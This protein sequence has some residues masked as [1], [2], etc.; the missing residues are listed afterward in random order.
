MTTTKIIR[1]RLSTTPAGVVLSVSDF[2]VE[3]RSQPALLKALNRLVQRGDL[4]RISKGR[5]YTPKKT[6]FGYLKP[7]DAEILKEFLVK[8]GK[9][10]GYITGT[11]AFAA[12]G[13]TTQISS[14]IVIGTNQ[15]RRPVDRV[16]MNISFLLQKN[17]ITPDSIPLLRMLDAIRLVKDI[18]AMTPD[19]TISIIRDKIRVLP[20]EKQYAMLRLSLAY[21]PYVRALIGAIS[22]SIGINAGE[23]KRTLNGVTFYRLPI[24]DSVLPNKKD[25][26]IV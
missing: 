7:T 17:E 14:S 11:A 9:T 8:D 22:D 24:S 12:M 18:P 16:G 15:Y 6:A 4:M 19:E 21:A 3:M 20:I 25:W 26:N 5:Y 13:L 23:I 1:E 2:G 10:I